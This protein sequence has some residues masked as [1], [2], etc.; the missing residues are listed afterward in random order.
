VFPNERRVNLTIDGMTMNVIL[1]SVP[2]TTFETI[3]LC[4]RNNASDTF[5]N[6]ILGKAKKPRSCTMFPGRISTTPMVIKVFDKQGEYFRHWANSMMNDFMNPQPHTEYRKV[7]TIK[8]KDEATGKETNVKF[9]G[10]FPISIDERYE[11]GT[12]ETT[13][14]LNVDQFTIT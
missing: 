7:G 14:E 6:W 5:I 4:M 3:E 8:H 2:E 9:E 1:D 12:I 10:I 11:L 13:I